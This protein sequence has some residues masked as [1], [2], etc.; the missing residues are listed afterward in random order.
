MEL[1]VDGE[2]EVAA[3][4]AEFGADV[5]THEPGTTEDGGVYAGLGLAVEFAAVVDVQFLLDGE[6]EGWGG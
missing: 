2:D 6:G 4:V 3:D 5:R 1:V